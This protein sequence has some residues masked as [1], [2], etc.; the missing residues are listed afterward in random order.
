[1]MFTLASF[2]YF[3]VLLLKIYCVTLTTDM[4]CLLVELLLVNPWSK[5]ENGK[6]LKF[7]DGQWGEVAPSNLLLLTK[8]ESQLWLSLYNLLLDEECRKKY[9]Y[10]ANNKNVILK[11]RAA[12]PVLS[13]LLSSLV[14]SSLHSLSLSPV[15]VFFPPLLSAHLFV[16]PLQL[17][18]FLNDVLIDQI[19]NLADLRNFLTS[20]QV[21]EPPAPT[22][23]PSSF[24]IQQ[25]PEIRQH[26]L[27]Q[28][29]QEVREHQEARVFPE[30]TREDEETEDELTRLSN[31]F[32]HVQ[33]EK[34]KCQTCHKANASKRCARCKKQW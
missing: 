22:S 32:R 10:T 8:T 5:K 3:V 21:H 4:I 7:Q 26:L 18:P 23:I 31:T 12:I 24:L 30:L 1:M 17:L 33:L 9:H 13:P 27:K 20:L 11:V 15:S 14:L 19:P 25:L 34:P 2:I 6:I 28:N 16:F 29:V